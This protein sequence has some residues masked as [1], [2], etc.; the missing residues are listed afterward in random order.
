MKSIEEWPT[1]KTVGEVRNFHELASFYHRFNKD[2]STIAAPL[3]AIIKKNESFKSNILVAK[4]K[5]F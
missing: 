5:V 2:F 1:P 4:Q 3:T